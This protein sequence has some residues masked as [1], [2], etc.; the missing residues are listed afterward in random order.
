MNGLA[1]IDAQVRCAPAQVGGAE[2][3]FDGILS[4]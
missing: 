1:T 3:R 4:T 2:P